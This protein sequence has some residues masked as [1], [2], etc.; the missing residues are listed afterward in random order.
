MIEQQQLEAAIAAL[1]AQRLTLGDAVVDSLLAAAR[2]KLAALIASTAAPSMPT[3]TLRQVSILFLDVVGSTALAQNLDPEAISAVMDG[4]LSRAAVVVR[5]HG[6]KVLQYAGDSILAVFGA[7]EAR[8]DDVERAARCGL[9]LLDLGKTLGAEVRAEH[10]HDGFDVRVGVHTGGVLLGG[11]VDADSSIRGIA[12]NIAA[13]MEQTAPAGAL[14]ISHDA[15]AQVRG[16]FEVERQ[17]PLAVKGVDE[18]VQSYLVLRAKA[19]SFRLGSRGI[20]GVATRMIGRDAELEALQDAFKRMFVDQKLAAVSVVADAGIGKSRLLYEFAAWTDVRLESFFIFR[21]RA[22]PQTQGQPFGLLR[23]IV[24]WRF[25][26]ADDDSVETARRKMEEGIVPLFVDEDGPDTAQ[27]HAHLLGGI[28]W[29]ESRHVE[30]ILDDPRQIRNRAFH[31][32]AELFRRIGRSDGSPVVLELEDLHW[33]DNES[34]DF[35][36]YLAEVDR[37][38]PLLIVAGTRPTLFERRASW[39]AERVHQRIELQ[40]LGRDMSRLLAGELLKKLPDVPV[41]LRELVIGGAEGNPFYMEELVKM[42]ID[43]GAID[44]GE[45]WKVNAERLLLAKV[46]PTLTGVLQARLDSLPAAERSTLQ[47]ASVIGPV[48]WD[49]ALLALDTTAHD[50]LPALVRRALALPRAGSDRDDLREYA[51][52]HHILHQVTYETVLKRTRRELH[53]KLARWLAAQTGLRANDVLGDA[54]RHFELAG[55]D[56]NAAEYHTR[57]A[58]HARTRMA[59]DAVLDHVQRALAMLDRMPGV[60]TR[61]LRWRLL[62]VREATLDIQGDRVAQGADIDALAELAEV[63]DDDRRRA[64]AG[65]RRSALAQRVADYAAMEAAAGQAVEWA[66]RA[67]DD[68]IRLLARRLQAMSLTFQ[69]R[70]AEGRAIAEEALAEAQALA[71]RR[72]EALCR[73]ALGVMLAMQSDDVGALSMDQQS[74]A[75]HRAIGDRRN[76]AIAHGNIGAGWLALGELTRARQELEECLRL[77]R[78]NGERALEVSP[79]CA[80]ATLALWQGNDAQALVHAL[81]AVDV[82]VAVQ[83]RDQEIAALC[84]VGE[85]ELALARHA[86][87]ARAFGSAHARATEISSPY[88]DD[89]SAGLARLALAVGDTETAMQA[90]APLLALGARTGDADDRLKGVEFPR[91]VEWTSHRVLASAGDPRASEWLARVHEALQLQAATIAD[92]GLRHGFLS[93]IPVHREIVAA[94][95]SRDTSNG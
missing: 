19:R 7:D 83:A 9:A 20:E 62:D 28:E 18:P 4:G 74:L 27:G 78:V 82:G 29:S 49:R 61:L 48:F 79:R 32:A 39:V 17:E 26:I 15:Y 41:A 95:A 64:H 14:R 88:R 25:Q 30:G 34:L 46:P 22:T 63:L 10:G 93:N 59:H 55:D 45:V 67:G 69:G 72:V 56:A 86:A 43:Q 42:L 77:M 52:K 2:A 44:T 8:E 68:E 13:R 54:A 94:W 66:L 38:V 58:E 47:Q 35:L 36:G 85:A 6:G 89:A 65:W 31:V 53:G 3:Q 80:L 87:A 12:V 90:L 84:R 16:L 81:E 5:A 23:D 76:E 1:Q 37:D 60:G 92:A 33:A 70:A 71:L 24:A 50:T 73:N 91:L 57:A 40:A 75:A 11:G 21:G 51:F